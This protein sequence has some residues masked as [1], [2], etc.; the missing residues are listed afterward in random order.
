[1]DHWRDEM[2]EHF[3]PSVFFTLFLVVDPLGL[4]P[5]F[6]M[7]L[8]G[9]SASFR[10]RIIIKATVI[11]FAVSVFFVVLGDYFLKFI[12]VSAAS[13]LIAGGALLFLIAIDM[14]FARDDR[15]RRPAA[16]AAPGVEEDVSVFPLAIPM[17]S[18]PGTIAAL[19]MFSAQV[20]GDA[21]GTLVII[22]LAAAVMMITMAVMFLSV[23]LKRLIG[24]TG[25]S[26]IQR[27]MGLI[28]SAMAVQF[29]VN[30]LKGIGIVQ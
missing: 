23:H 1:M 16:D 5:V 14:L 18:G 17:I 24:E 21:R 3:I 11:A 20:R 7:Y 26:V 25:I 12:G 27:L 22:A 8:Q 10:R 13:F 9:Y 30:G 29:I 19:L 4:I 6:V 15:T 2:S 28:L